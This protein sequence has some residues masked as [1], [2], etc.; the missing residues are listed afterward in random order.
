MHDTVPSFVLKI[1]VNL[2]KNQTNNIDSCDSNAVII[3]NK[4]TIQYI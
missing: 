1:V 3:K 2:V 4:L